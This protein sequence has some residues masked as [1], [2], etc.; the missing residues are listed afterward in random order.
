MELSIKKIIAL[1]FIVFSLNE[2]TKLFINFYY[3][4]IK[5]SGVILLGQEVNIRKEVQVELHHSS[6]KFLL[7]S[8]DN[9]LLMCNADIILSNTYY[10]YSLIDINND[11]VYVK[12]CSGYNSL[13]HTL[14][15]ISSLYKQSNINDNLVFEI[16]SSRK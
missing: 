15:R 11:N 4:Q 9:D 2:L 5:I 8:K 6:Y 1:T 3:S 13:E 16:F 7:Y 14:L 10:I 12:L